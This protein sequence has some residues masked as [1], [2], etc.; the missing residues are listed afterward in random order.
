M[1]LLLEIDRLQKA[2]PTWC[3]IGITIMEEGEG[4]QELTLAEARLPGDEE[5]DSRCKIVKVEVFNNRAFE[6]N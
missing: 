6:A 2:D 1:T 3:S 4:P 5:G